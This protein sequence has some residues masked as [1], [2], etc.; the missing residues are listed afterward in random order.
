[1]NG[2]AADGF[3]LQ[4]RKWQKILCEAF[5]IGGLFAHPLLDFAPMRPILTP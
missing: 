5:V 4:A 1:L 3:I 2:L